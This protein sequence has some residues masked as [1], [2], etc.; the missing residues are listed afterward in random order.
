M[1]VLWFFGNRRTR[2]RFWKPGGLIAGR[3]VHWK[4]KISGFGSL[5]NRNVDGFRLPR[6]DQPV[7]SGFQNHACKATLERI[8]IIIIIIILK[9]ERENGI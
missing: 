2:A 6:S 4:F 9:R 8:I 5:K 7:Q 3:K 1:F